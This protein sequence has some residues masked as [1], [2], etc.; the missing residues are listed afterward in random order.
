[1]TERRLIDVDITDRADG[2]I[3]AWDDDDNTHKYIEP[4]GISTQAVRV[5]RN[6][7][8]SSI[9]SGGTAIPWD[10]E[11]R[12]D[13]GFF[14]SG[15]ATRLTAP[16]D[17]WYCIQYSANSGATNQDSFVARLRLDGTTV[18]SS[19]RHYEATNDVAFQLN[20]GTTIYLTENQYVEL[21]LDVGATQTVRGESTIPGSMNMSMFKVA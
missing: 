15:S 4:A 20:G 9:S 1:M 17:G 10:N 13:G 21:L 12:D 3:P 14:D 16:A 5:T 11:V 2:R 7:D 19:N 6:A 18:I 8:Y